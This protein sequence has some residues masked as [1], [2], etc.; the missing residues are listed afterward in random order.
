MIDLFRRNCN[1]INQMDVTT[2]DELVMEYLVVEGYKGS[3]IFS[4]YLT[5]V[6]VRHRFFRVFLVSTTFLIKI[7]TAYYY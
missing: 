6:E 7:I 1:H 4:I 3:W 2:L 5:V